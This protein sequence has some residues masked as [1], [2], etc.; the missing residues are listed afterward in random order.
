[1]KTILL[2]AVAWSGLLAAVAWAEEEPAFLRHLYPPDLVMR[3]AAAIQ[4]TRQQRERITA[5]IQDVQA[6]VLEVQWEMQADARK[7]GEQVASENVDEATVLA[8]ARRI[9]EREVTVKEAHLGLLIRIRNLL[10][11]EQRAQLRP[12]REGGQ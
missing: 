2:L 1:M 5:D 9:F 11:P 10:T 6:R 7:L 12:L 8:T 4:L 3:E